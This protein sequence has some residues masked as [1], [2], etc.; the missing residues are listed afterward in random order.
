MASADCVSSAGVWSY[1]TPIK[2]GTGTCVTRS[3]VNSA[4]SRVPWAGS[5]TPVARAD[6]LPRAD[7]QWFDPKT[8][9]PTRRF[10][11]FMR[12][13]AEERLGGVRGKSVPQVSQDVDT[14][15]TAVVATTSYATQVGQYA[16]SVAASADATAQVAK[17][18]S[19]PGWETIPE[20][21]RD[22]P[23]FGL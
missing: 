10:Y 6:W 9:R 21:P 13:V 1:A 15:R 22:P 7:E 5:S 8:G 18:S 16:A 12:E 2:Q 20:V 19:L 23:G 3:G 14:T 4:A 17:A 11:Q